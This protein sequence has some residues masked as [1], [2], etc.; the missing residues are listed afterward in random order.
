MQDNDYGVLLGTII[1]TNET[2][3]T[4]K[5]EFV[6]ANGINITK[7]EIVEILDNDRRIIASIGEIRRTNAYYSSVDVAK[8]QRPT[9][10]F[11]SQEWESSVATCIILGEIVW[12][13]SDKKDKIQKMSFPPSPGNAV[14][15]VTD[16]SL[17]IFMGFKES[18]GIK[19]GNIYPSNVPVELDV[20][21]LFR[22]HLAI[23]A[24]SGAG[25]SYSTAVLIE[26]VMDMKEGNQLPIVIIDPHGEYS[27]LSKIPE[28]KERTTVIK[29]SYFAID[30]S[31][32]NA[33]NFR[34]YSPK[35]SAVQVR[36]LQS[37]IDSLKEK[38]KSYDIRDIIRV[39]GES[40]QINSK[41]KESLIS[42][43]YQLDRTHFFSNIE[44]PRLKEIIKPGKLIIFDLSDIYGFQQKQI[45]TS[46]IARK[47]FN[48]RRNKSISPFLLIIE[49]AHNFCPEGVESISRSIIETIARE[50][51]KFFASLCLISQR[52]VRLSTTALSQCNTHLILRIRNPYDL[53]FVG[54]Q[55]EGINRDTINAIPDLNIGEGI[56][57][58]EAVNYPVQFKIRKKKYYS[59]EENTNLEEILSEY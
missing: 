54:K 16:R 19:L 26:E 53:D 18:G 15:R 21:R 46:Y 12:N 10:L 20:T 17:R 55:S 24:I 42:W 25:K 23:L 8:E 35:I 34:E 2:P 29:G 59:K 5:L 47:A 38:G 4:R 52:P 45:L 7:G 37:I 6:L 22:K 56:L 57:V 43:L 58:G 9:S 31:S 51:R 14:R 48:Y 13:D 44:N 36:E 27:H 39:L 28:Y 41:T 1:T 11:P 33:W 3:S 30:T 50:G 49:E 32:L 40:D